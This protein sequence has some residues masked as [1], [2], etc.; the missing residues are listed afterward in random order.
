MTTIETEKFE[1][2]VKWGWLFVLGISMIILG[3]IGMASAFYLTVASVILFG[4]FMFAGG[5]LQLWHGI[6]TKEIK[7][8]G[9]L[10]HIFVA[11]C[12][13][14]LG[15]LLLW[16][17]ISGSLSLTLLLAGI[18]IAIG[19]ARLVYSWQCRKRG[20]QWALPFFGGLIDLLLAGLIFYGWPGTAFWVI[21]LF[22]AI[23]MIINGWLLTGI[24][25]AVRRLNNESKNLTSHDSDQLHAS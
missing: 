1:L 12:Y 22:V 19:V 14:V 21:G 2:P 4:S 25:L 20:W 13:L 5:V 15:G 7:W 18:L 17:P 11:L 23:E 16:D 24:A 9:R 8:S 6:V 3:T 10:L